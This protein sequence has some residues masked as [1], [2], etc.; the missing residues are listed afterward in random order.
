MTIVIPRQWKRRR[1]LKQYKDMTDEE[2]I[3]FMEE[4]EGGV[5]LN[6][7]KVKGKPKSM[8]DVGEEL[9][10][11]P[12]VSDEEF[13][14]RVQ[15]KFDSL[16]EGY[17][18]SGMKAND[19]ELTNALCWAFVQLEVYQTSIRAMTSSTGSIVMFEPIIKSISTMMKELRADISKMQIDLNITRK[20]RSSDKDASVVSA[21]DSLQKSARDFYDQKMAYIY[22]P[23]CRQLLSTTWFLYPNGNNIIELV[24]ERKL[25]EQEGNIC[26]HKTIITSKELLEKKQTNHPDKFTF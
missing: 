3:A 9:I 7:T 21:W 4:T 19:L 12:I 1:N 24:C 23:K 13:A 25:D 17:D 14:E 15:A 20:I 10:D 6:S 16:E 26:G 8:K 5:T 22:C 11:I 2:F 18:L